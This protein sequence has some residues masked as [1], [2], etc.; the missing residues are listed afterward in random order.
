MAEQKLLFH[1]SLALFTDFYELTMAYGYWKAG[2]QDKEAVFHLTFRNNPFQG[3]F[4]VACGL[5]YVIDY[6]KHFRF[7]DDDL[8]HLASFHGIDGK[9]I[10]N[11]EFLKYLSGFRFECDLDAVPEGTVVFPHEPLVRV[12]GPLIQSQILESVFLNFINFQTLIATKAARVCLAAEGDDVVEF[13]MR[14][15][16]GID[17][18][19]AASRASYIGGCSSTSNVLAGKLFGIPVKGTHAHSWVMAFGDELEAF[20]AYAKAIPNNCIFLVDTYDSIDGINRAIHVAK[21]MRA[22]GHKLIGIRLDSGDLAYLSRL[23]RKMLDDAGFPNVKVV[24]SNELD[25][26]TIASVKHEGGKVDIWGIGTKLVTAHDDPALGGI[27]KLSAIRNRNEKWQYKVKISEQTIKIN[28][29][30]IHQVRRY[31]KAGENI[32]DVIYDEGTDLSK[33]CTIVDQTDMTRQKIIEASTSFSDLLVPVFRSGKCV[34]EMPSI[35]DIRIKVHDELER[36]H[37]GIKR[38][39]NPHRYPAGI[40]K[41]LFDLKTNLVLKTKKLHQAAV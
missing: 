12:K 15:A 27:Y 16:Q 33:G 18:A 25:E 4:A 31:F 35:R 30:G 11:S 24:V 14:R 8:N 23:A 7:A 6:L 39:V 28:N 2:I 9:P 29:P 34:Y 22:E 26:H 37:S 10:F 17:G 20:R 41:S 3:G 19:L 36:F 5:E 40:E 38:F 1:P 32:A 13:G 21:E